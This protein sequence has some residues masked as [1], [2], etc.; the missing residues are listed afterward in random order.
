MKILNQSIEAVPI[1]DL[2]L[3]PRNANRGDVGAISESIAANGFWGTIVAQRST[4]YVLAGNHR[5]EAAKESGAAEVPVA[6]VDVDDEAALRILLAD[7]RTTRLGED[8]PEALVDLLRELAETDAGLAGTGF[9]DDDLAA[10]IQ[11]L[12]APDADEWGDALGGLPDGDRAP[13][14]QKTFTLHDEQAETVERALEVAKGIGPF[15]DSPN[16]NSN[17]NAL[18]RVC[19]MFL[20]WADERGAGA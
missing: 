20:M 6:W 11:G 12:E 16:E 8:E 2:K 4:G 1:A 10:I 13:F 3:H 19:E 7:N 14:Q 5:L 18:A 9:G 15:V 17:G